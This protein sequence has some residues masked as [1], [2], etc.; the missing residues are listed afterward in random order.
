[1]RKSFILAICLTAATVA[2]AQVRVDPVTMR[3]GGDLAQQGFTFSLASQSFD[4]ICEDTGQGVVTIQ[5]ASYIGTLAVP[6]FDPDPS[7]SFIHD[8]AAVALFDGEELAAA[9]NEYTLVLEAADNLGINFNL[10]ITEID[11]GTLR[12]AFE[13]NGPF[14][15]GFL[16]ANDLANGAQSNEGVAQIASVLGA[17]RFPATIV[18]ETRIPLGG[19]ATGTL[20]VCLGP[21][22]QTRIIDPENNGDWANECVASG[23]RPTTIDVGGGL[24]LQAALERAPIAT[25]SFSC[26]GPTVGCVAADGSNA[27]DLTANAPVGVG[28]SAG[29]EQMHRW[30]KFLSATGIFGGVNLLVLGGDPTEP[31][32][33]YIEAN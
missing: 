20:S 27:P 8:I 14:G 24:D 15:G 3:S 22:G 30:G 5:G 13:G 7:E 4:T 17:F 19:G 23:W 16:A 12:S 18:P 32:S 31:S 28:I 11:E 26:A 10:N 33:L 2:S 29:G 6:G 21:T 25:C 1:M 9:G